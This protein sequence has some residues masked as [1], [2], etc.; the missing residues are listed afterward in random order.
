MA[1]KE[2]KPAFPIKHSSTEVLHST[3]WKQQQIK[4]GEQL[5]SLL[6]VSASCVTPTP[7]CCGAGSGALPAHP[8]VT[9][10]FRAHPPAVT[11]ARS[12]TTPAPA[13]RQRLLAAPTRAAGQLQGDQ[14]R[15]GI[16][17]S[18]NGFINECHNLAF[19]ARQSCRKSRFLKQRRQPDGGCRAG[20]RRSEAAA[21]RPLR[22]SSRVPAAALPR[23]GFP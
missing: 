5:V 21:C 9:Q 20:S 18:E 8:A 2:S 17:A 22:K 3:L 14:H 23:P 19:Q 10:P 1:D 7:L 12:G 16:W 6:S 11:A 15:R 13:L 4:R